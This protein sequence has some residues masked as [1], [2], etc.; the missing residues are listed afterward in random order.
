MPWLRAVVGLGAEAGGGHDVTADLSPRDPDAA[1]RARASFTA[2]L[3]CMDLTAGERRLITGAAEDFG[4]RMVEAYARRPAPPVPR[5]RKS[6]E[7]A[8]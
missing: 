2:L 1:E 4:A 6:P 7:R 5:P 8:G 3:A